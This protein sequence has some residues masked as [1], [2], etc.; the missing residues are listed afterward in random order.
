MKHSPLAL[1]AVL[2]AL[3]AYLVGPSFG[4]TAKPRAQDKASVWM[5]KKLEFSRNIL[6]ALTT[7]DFDEIRRNAENMTFVGYLEKWE[8]GGQPDYKRQVTYFEF[9]SQELIRHAKAK[10]IDGATLAFNQLATSCIQCHKVV[11]DAKKK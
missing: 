4:Q 10:N 1:A 9:A 6:A 8:R 7:A 2:L 5:E 11:R 3:A